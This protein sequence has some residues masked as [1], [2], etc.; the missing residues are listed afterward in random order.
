MST[1]PFKVG[2]IGAGGIAPYAH[3]ISEKD[4]RR[5]DRRGRGR[6]AKALDK[7]QGRIQHP[8]NV[9]SDYKEMLKEEN[10]SRRG[11]RL[12]AQ[13]PARRQ[14]D[15]RA[16]SGQARARR[17]ADGDERQGRPED[18]RRRQ[19]GGKQLVI[20]FQYRFDP[21]TQ[22]IRE[23]IAGR[24]VRQD[25]V[26]PLPGA[27]PPRHPELGRLRPEGTQGGGPMIDIGVH[28]LEM[29]HYMIG[30]PE[31]VTATGNT[32]TYHRQ[33]AVRTSRRMWPNWDHKT[34]TVEDMAVG[35]IRFDNGDDA[36]DRSRA[37]SR[38]SKRTSGTSRSWAKRAARTGIRPDLQRPAAA[39]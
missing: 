10:G 39:T 2:F 7:A 38:T 16:R 36:H 26:R 21:Q 11:Q 28:I 22:V 20:G 13:R 32:W 19:E 4:R 1:K 9:Y 23:Q 15:R 35:M 30:S 17:E 34:Y 5:R 3:E 29:A 24:R 31:P 12:H 25:H 8:A 33:Q 27:A 14:H 6:L 37:S 18:D